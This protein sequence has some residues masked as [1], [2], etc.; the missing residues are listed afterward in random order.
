[1]YTRERPVNLAWPYLNPGSPLYRGL[2]FAGLGPHPGGYTYY[3]CSP[4]RN[5]GTLTNMDPS[6]WVFDPYLGR[7]ATTYNGSDEK[8]TFATSIVN[9]SSGTF[10]A[11]IRSIATPSGVR[12]L[13]DSASNFS[14]YLSGSTFICK[15]GGPNNT[16]GYAVSFSTG[17]V[18]H[19]AMTW[20]SSIFRFF[21]WWNGVN[22]Q[23]AV[24]AGQDVGVTQ[25]GQ[26]YSTSLPWIGHVI[27]PLMYSRAL[28]S[29][30]I[31]QLADPSNVMLSGL[32]LPPRR[33]LWPV[34]NTAYAS[35]IEL[36]TLQLSI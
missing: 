33:V 25:I 23:S 20:D 9:K 32:V 5:S 36:P 10:A 27:D 18:A 3:D 7:F 12:V 28:S 4:Y 30:E 24:P 21:A 31:Q 19:V 16:P 17:T 2:V 1:M 22:V 15:A 14:V 11:W 35:T 26:Y 13:F 29:S 6:N 8:C 34:A